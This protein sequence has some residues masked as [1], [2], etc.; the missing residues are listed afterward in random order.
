M[1][2]GTICSAK[3]RLGIFRKGHSGTFF[4]G[5]LRRTMYVIYGEINNNN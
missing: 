3:F 4:S 1:L 2:T 5:T